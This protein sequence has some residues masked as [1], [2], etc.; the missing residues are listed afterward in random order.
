[1]TVEGIC[2][3]VS[4]RAGEPLM[5]DAVPFENLGPGLRP[6]EALRVVR[7][8]TFRIF[9]RAFAFRAPIFLQDVVGNDRRRRV[10]LIEG[11]QV[12]NVFW[13]RKGKRA[14]AK[15]S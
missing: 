4:F 7:P 2:G 1:V 3:D 11:E 14:H 9:Q 12:G 6:L 15:T 5:M 8:K 13:F 10:F